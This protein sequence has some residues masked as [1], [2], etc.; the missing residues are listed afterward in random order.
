[1]ATA[2]LVWKG[3]A[4]RQKVVTA[5]ISGL[6][7]FALTHETEAK[8]EL[9]PRRGVVTGTL[10]R[11]IHAANPEYSY[12]KDHVLS[13]PSTPERG[14]GT[15]QLAERGGKVAVVVGSGMRYAR[16]IENRYSYMMRS[17]GRMLPRLEP[18]IRK[19]AKRQGL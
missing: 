12:Q 18:I 7:E 1:M 6:Q 13:S 19:H 16:R 17:Y 11:S 10:R 15:P 2:R 9:Q 4:V 14:R 8:S 3:P 5:V